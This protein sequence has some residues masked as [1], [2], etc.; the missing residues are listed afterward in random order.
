M[1]TCVSV[2]IIG[3]G[4][5]GAH[6]ANS[7]MLQ[8]IADEL[9]LCDIASGDED[10]SRKLAAEVQDLS[11][12]LAFCS[13]NVR[14]ESCGEDYAALASCDVVVNAAGKVRL[15][16]QDRD[17]ELFYTTDTARRFIP[18]LARAGFSGV[19]VTVANP[20]DVVATQ[21][22][23]L[24]GFDP[25]RV[26]GTGTQLDS[27]RF[28][29]VLSRETGID[30][31]SVGAY[32]LGEHGATQFAC[33]SQVN[34]GGKPLAEL[35][36]EEPARFSLDR[37]ALEDAAR[38]AIT[39]P[40]PARCAPSTPWP[41]PPRVWCGPWCPTS[42]R[43]WP[44]PPSWTASTARRACS[45]PCPASWVAPVWRPSWCP[46]SPG[47]SRPPS[48][49]AAPT[50]ARTWAAWAWSDR[51]LGALRTGPARG[52]PSLAVRRGT[53]PRRHSRISRAVSSLIKSLSG[54]DCC[55]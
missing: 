13:H 51:P 29:H 55:T 10:N 53:R 52:A 12:S 42:T 34:F 22:W 24:G 26:I 2:G 46:T 5:V 4:H 54:V 45:A 32:M 44:A 16:A 11:D 38:R 20:C 8:G 48:T 1:G 14:I 21:I 23:K 17:G 27:A 36:R 18:V 50:S 19:W 7:L 25:R 41:T 30:Q 49:P 3:L 28:R 37:P 9:L 15:A 47:R 39:W 31:H 40:W 33:W 35:E 43:C 6:V